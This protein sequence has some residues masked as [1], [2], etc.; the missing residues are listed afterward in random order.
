MRL[1]MDMN[2]SVRSKIYRKTAAVANYCRPR[3]ESTKEKDLAGVGTKKSR[4]SRN[5]ES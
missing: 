4:G 5:K 3:G 2:I 1:S